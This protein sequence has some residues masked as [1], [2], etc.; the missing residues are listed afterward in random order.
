MAGTAGDDGR[1]TPPGEAE[2][3]DQRPL[4]GRRSI[5]VDLLLYP[6]HSIP[7]AAAP[8]LVGLGLAAHDGVL[9][10]GPALLGFLGSWLIH[11]AGVFIDNHELLRLHP[12]VVEHPELTEAVRSGA[13]RLRALA[14]ATAACLAGALL[15]VP[16]LYR[17]GGSPVLLLEAVGVAASL[18]YA[19]GPLAYARRGLAD[20][21][22][23]L[24]FGVV[25][26][27]G[28]YYIQAVARGAL[29]PGLASLA[30]LPARAWLVGLP[31]GALV[32]NVMLIDDL[33]DHA[34]DR[35]KGWR[36]GSVRFGEAFTRAEITALAAAAL[37]APL[38]FWLGLG[39]GAWVLLPLAAVPM[40]WRTVRALRAAVGRRPE[41]VPLT[42]RMARLALVHAAL[43]GLGLALAAP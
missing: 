28:T 27:A 24:M 7:T 6:T 25:G 32:V 20:L 22:F 31:S 21:V 11:V 30:S 40:G 42:P 8:V 35:R 29:P 1:G 5:W 4:L 16:W 39:L 15:T 34:F 19:G 17:L 37:A 23:L 2:L 3:V 18:C 43:L 9:A 36:T 14:W 41:L 10:P 12:E 33:R 38:L 13:L 26:V